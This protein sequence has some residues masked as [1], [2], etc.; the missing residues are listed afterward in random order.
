MS[1]KNWVCFDCRL[2]LRRGWGQKEPLCPTCGKK[3]Y[4]LGYKVRVP[5]ENKVKEWEQLRHNFLNWMYH[6]QLLV[7]EIERLGNL[8]ATAERKKTIASLHSKL[9]ALNRTFPW[10]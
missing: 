8:P 6:Y 7:R 9:I 5:P 1:S 2:T 4:Y 3:C 10:T